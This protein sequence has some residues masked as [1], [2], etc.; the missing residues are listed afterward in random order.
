M[1]ADNAIMIFKSLVETLLFETRQVSLPYFSPELAII[2]TIV[3]L[4]LGRLLGTERWL[5][6]SVLALGGCLLA[7]GLS[8]INFREV[9][10]S[11]PDGAASTW[12]GWWIATPSDLPNARVELFTGMLV[13]DPLTVFFRVFLLLFT[14]CVIYLMMISGIPDREDA[15]DFFT[16]LLG[17]T[18]GMMLMASAN[19]LLMVFLAV[20]MTSV[21]SYAMVGF[22]K[23]RKDSSEAAL[24]YVVYGGGAAGVMLYG[25]SLLCGLA[26]TAHL[27]S[28]AGALQSLVVEKGTLADPELR[29]L[30]LA[31]LLIFVGISFKLSLFPFHFWCPDAFQGAL[32]EV[33][34][35]LSVASKGAAFA[36]LL[37]FCLAFSSSTADVSHLVQVRDFMAIALGLIAIITATF[38][39]LA[40]YTQTNMKRLL[41]YSTIAHAGYMLMAVVALVVILNSP[42]SGTDAVQERSKQAAEC[43]QHLLFYLLSYFFMNLGAFAIVAFIRNRIFSEEIEHY[44]GLIYQSPVLAVGMLICLFSLVGLPPMGG[45]F[46]KFGVFWSVFQ[47]I[48][49]QPLLMWTVLAAGCLNTVFSLFFYIRVLKTMFLGQPD[50]S[51]QT[52][53]VDVASNSGRYVVLMCLPVLLLGIFAGPILSVTGDVAK[54]LFR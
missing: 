34:G 38:G 5:S 25:I 24:K 45:F 31:V 33:A 46:G 39:N 15:P 44:S 16:L 3:L 10:G 35:Y 41:A 50:P 47:A 27:P 36:V 29:A 4:L 52:V 48:K 28:L 26:G 1:R 19:H 43:V 21:P 14:I 22:L 40:A 32:A 18:L 42:A 7:L 30:L 37:R 51:R 54:F 13:Y 9:M 6:G 49:Y 53:D 8:L 12:L 2:G 23:G 20:E 17:S 11:L